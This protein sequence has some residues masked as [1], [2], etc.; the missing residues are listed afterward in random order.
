MI[1]KPLAIVILLV[2]IIRMVSI[3]QNNFSYI[4][5]MRL[6]QFECLLIILQKLMLQILIQRSAKAAMALSLV[7]ISSQ[8]V[9]EQK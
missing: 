8:S 2:V 3:N 5:G 9:W 7:I 1:Q 4:N 6:L